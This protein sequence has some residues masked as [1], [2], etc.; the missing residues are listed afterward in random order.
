MWLQVH[1]SVEVLNLLIGLLYVFINELIHQRMEI[2]LFSK[3]TDEVMTIVEVTGRER[4]KVS[5]HMN[6]SDLLC[7][8]RPL[9][10]LD[11]FCNFLFGTMPKPVFQPLLGE[12]HSMKH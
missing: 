8:E 11:F 5:F 2:L 10:L 9:I 7:G 6:V 3:E 12:P 4:I 1:L